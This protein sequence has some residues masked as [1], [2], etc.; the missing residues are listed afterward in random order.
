MAT[1]TSNTDFFST[2][3]RTL[4]LEIVE[5]ISTI[6]SRCKWTYKSHLMM[7]LNDFYKFIRHVVLIKIYWGMMQIGS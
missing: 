3:K 4:P 7:R 2:M 5:K 1:P 6:Q